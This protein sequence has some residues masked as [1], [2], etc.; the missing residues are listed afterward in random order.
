[1][2]KTFLLIIALTLLISPAEA[3][4]HCDH[5]E[6]SNHIKHYQKV[7]GFKDMDTQP[8]SVVNVL[9]QSD[10]TYITMQGNLTKRLTDDT[11]NFSDGTDNIS[12]EIDD[13][14]WKGQTISPKDKVVIFGKIDEEDGQKT[15]DAKSINIIN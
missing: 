12:V 5:Q 3:K 2:K 11:Y 14:V 13:E 1:M 8:I 15:V 7:G 10:G 4:H 6:C 9:K